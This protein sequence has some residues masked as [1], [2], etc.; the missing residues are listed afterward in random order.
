MSEPRQVD[1]ILTRRKEVMIPLSTLVLQGEVPINKWTIEKSFK[2]PPTKTSIECGALEFNCQFICDENSSDSNQRNNHNSTFSDGLASPIYNCKQNPVAQILS[3]HELEANQIKC[4]GGDS[5]S[6]ERRDQERQVDSDENNN[7]ESGNSDSNHESAP[8]GLPQGGTSGGGT[9]GGDSH[10]SSSSSTSSRCTQI[11]YTSGNDEDKDQD[12][13]ENDCPRYDYEG[14]MES[15]NDTRDLESCIDSPSK[16]YEN[17]GSS[18]ASQVRHSQPTSAE[19]SY[20]HLLHTPHQYHHL[21]S[22]HDE[23]CSSSVNIDDNQYDSCAQKTA[24]NLKRLKHRQQENPIVSSYQH[25]MMRTSCTQKSTYSETPTQQ[26]VLKDIGGKSHLHTKIYQ[27]ESQHCQDESNNIFGYDKSSPIVH[28]P[29]SNDI[30]A[31]SPTKVQCDTCGMEFANK[32][33]LNRHCQTVHSSRP[34]EKVVCRVCSKSFS[35]RGNRNKHERAKH[36]IRFCNYCG[37]TLR[38]SPSRPTAHETGKLRMCFCCSKGNSPA[39]LQGISSAL[40]LAKFK[41]FPALHLPQSFQEEHPPFRF[42]DAQ[43]SLHAKTFKPPVTRL[44]SPPT[45]D[46]PFVTTHAL[47]GDALFTSQQMH[48][49]G[50]QPEMHT[51][52]LPGEVH[53]EFFQPSSSVET[54]AVLS[55]GQPSSFPFEYML[56]SSNSQSAQNAQ[57]LQR[58]SNLDAR[59]SL[60]NP[61]FFGARQPTDTSIPQSCMTT[62]DLEV[63]AHSTHSASSHH[64]QRSSFSIPIEDISPTSMAAKYVDEHSD[65]SAQLHKSVRF[66]TDHQIAI[67]RQGRRSFPIAQLAQ[68]HV[69][70]IPSMNFFQVE[71]L[72]HLLQNPEL[73]FHAGI[74]HDVP[75]LLQHLIQSIRPQFLQE[76]N[77]QEEESHQRSEY[78]NDHFLLQLRQLQQQR[79]LNYLQ[80]YQ[81]QSQ[82]SSRTSH[83]QTVNV[84]STPEQLAQVEQS[85]HSQ[86]EQQMQQRCMTSLPNEEVHYSQRPTIEHENLSPVGYVPFNREMSRDLWAKQTSAASTQRRAQDDSTN[87]QMDL[88]TRGTSLLSPTTTE[89][90]PYNLSE[91]FFQQ[92]IQPEQ[93]IH[94]FSLQNQPPQENLPHH[95]QTLTSVETSGQQYQEAERFMMDQQMSDPLTSQLY[96]PSSFDFDFESCPLNSQTDVATI[97][98][99]SQS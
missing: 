57:S 58:I 48:E 3:I 23:L 81:H 90:G 91:E 85:E 53:G 49:Q 99:T 96:I 2:L 54:S 39:P 94:D 86:L 26:H 14:D 10:N 71:L 66:P 45:P 51:T 34:R 60:N 19:L 21:Q 75:H 25:N 37:G 27:D 9:G 1:T 83:H 78:L 41:N 22:V 28:L 98:R 46:M 44:N 52:S 35:S 20:R 29:Q 33:S 4:T 13:E 5:S 24:D 82:L 59:S 93:S 31:S 79:L 47:F 69:S 62:I 74:R 42:E 84:G 32:F 43:S 12:E 68:Q 36:N 50:H 16:F 11:E 30:Q 77:Q 38:A 61:V 70:S 65:E 67:P 7:H 55:M 95:H 80:H 17:I 89:A 73:F 87:L 63:P 8:L 76:R 92:C 6:D 64:N 40:D 88:T 15:S 18:R 56:G 72:A 97:P